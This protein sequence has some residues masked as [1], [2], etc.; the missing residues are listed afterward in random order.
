MAEQSEAPVEQTDVDRRAP[1]VLV[2]DGDRVSRRFVELALANEGFVIEAVNDASAALEVL[3]TQ[4]VDLIVSETMLPD[5]NG[6]KFY[7]RLQQESRLR[8]VP[9]VFLSSDTQARTKVLALR[10]GVEDYLCKPSDPA[11]FAARLSA[12]IGRHR[13]RR[14]EASNRS[15]TLAGD[16]SAIEFSDLVAIIEMGHRSG[17]LAMLNREASGQVFFDEGRVVHAVYGNL[18]GAEAFYRFVWDREGQFEFA[19]GPCTL[20]QEERTIS[21]S[22]TGLIMEGACRLDTA[23]NGDSAS[24]IK[25]KTAL[26]AQPRRASVKP[27]GYRAPAPAPDAIVARHYELALRESFALGDLKMFGEADL[28]KWTAAEPGRDRFHV[29]LIAALDEAVSAVLPLAGAATERWVLDSLSPGKK[30]LGLALWLRDERLVDLVLIDA[31]DPAALQNSLLRVPSVV[32]VAPPKGDLMALGTQA[33]VALHGLLD[34]LCA[35]V[36]VGIGQPTLQDGL[37]R[38]GITT[39]DSRRVSCVRGGLSD[40]SSDLRSLLIAAIG[41]WVSSNSQLQPLGRGAV[42]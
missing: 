36:V 23:Q 42:A 38:I 29:L 11:E 28:A 6:L 8:H 9:F 41:V 18:D 19:T 3:G 39:T 24:E 34:E 37:S 33:R 25:P 1:T 5:M 40:P 30:A 4:V 16:F 26:G 22:A 14:N 17:I 20:S 27:E 13:R 15:Y 21:Q 31:R 32:I 12:I 7:R 10:A 35:R 2:V